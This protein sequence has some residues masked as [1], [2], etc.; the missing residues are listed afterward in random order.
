MRAAGHRHKL[1][2]LMQT[3]RKKILRAKQKVQLDE[4]T[5][6]QHESSTCEST[7]SEPSADSMLSVQ[8]IVSNGV[9]EDLRTR[10]LLLS[11]QGTVSKSLYTLQG[12][13]GARQRAKYAVRRTRGV[14]KDGAPSPT[15]FLSTPLRA[16]AAMT[17]LV[18][19]SQRAASR[20]RRAVAPCFAHGSSSTGRMK[21]PSLE[22]RF[23]LE[24][25]LSGSSAEHILD[26][27]V[28][29]P[30]P[31]RRPTRFHAVPA[32]EG[33]RPRLRR[34][35]PAFTPNASSGGA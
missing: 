22:S 32:P 24:Q 27:Q 2:T 19:S 26:K 9:D 23:R 6:V 16:S 15:K 5:C 29:S 1:I 31:G 28:A 4:L 13:N 3:R 35:L 17:P 14:L 11:K 30:R 7:C 12:V 18:H 21:P 20:L 8:R 34:S 33:R 10:A 25:G